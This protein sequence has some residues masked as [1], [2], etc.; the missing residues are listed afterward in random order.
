MKL[1]SKLLL[2]SVVTAVVALGCGAVN[3]LM[4]KR[5][6]AAIAANY[7]EDITQLR[8]LTG[9][10]AQ[11]GRTHAGVYR[12]FS[13]IGSM[14]EAKVSAFRAEVSKQVQEMEAAVT[15]VGASLGDKPELV[16]GAN[17]LKAQLGVYAKQAD[18]AID[19][20]SVDPNTGVAAMQSADQ[21]FSETSQHATAFVQAIQADTQAAQEASVARS[22]RNALL[23]GALSVLLTG[24][25]LVMGAQVLRRVVQALRESAQVAEA[26]AH[27]DL[28]PR[29]VQARS[30]EIGDLQR[31]MTQ[32]V[33]RLRTSL[34]DV[35]HAASSI[36]SASTQI[37]SGNQDLSQR[38]EQA[39]SNLQETSS[40][41]EHL[42]ASVR[43]SADAA[44]QANQLASSASAVAERGGKAVAEVVTTMEEIN[45]AS[46]KIADIIGVIDGIAFQ[47]NILAL[48]AA[49]EAAR[50]GEQGRG[51]A[52][53]AG[54][55][56][57]LAGRSADA[58]RE[59]KGLIGASV[60]RVESGTR[61]VQGA[62]TTMGEIVAS[63]RRVTDIVGEITAGTSEQRDGIGQV[64][65]AVSQLDQMTQQNAA[66]VEQS[67]A[68]ADSMRQQA[69]RLSDMVAGFKLGTEPGLFTTVAAPVSAPPLSAPPVLHERVA[70][71]AISTAIHTAKTS[72]RAPAPPK[73][74]PP[75]PPP[76]LAAP[77]DDWE[78]F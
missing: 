30:D 38:T 21:A 68:A 72:A 28:S 35:R 7:T 3:S 58:A 52:V 27:G 6:A 42:T 55:V 76:A 46:R 29:A 5:E 39:A 24:V 41:M 67:A 17:K 19:L 53:V 9:A 73:A 1:G 66:L 37:A 2:P 61:L 59:I 16:E 11:L 13:L 69:Q 64:N 57:S 40:S 47:T 18:Q 62:G 12:T 26:V 25:A 15:S 49:V 78:S 23:L 63:V 65:T 56:R 45:A 10:Q 22:N 48:N 51:F 43:Q 54:E 77:S 44:S 71:T 75:A 36:A 31:S 34:L 20:A 74:Q 50:A 60:E 32:M 70:Q 33:E 4:M 8:A 14:D